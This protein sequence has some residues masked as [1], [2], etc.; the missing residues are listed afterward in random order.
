MEKTSDEKMMDARKSQQ[1]KL[2]VA[3]LTEIA[4]VSDQLG[5]Q[6]EG[7]E[8]QPTDL[9]KLA[10]RLRATDLKKSQIRN[11][12]NVAYTTDKISDITDLL[13]KLIGRDT[14][15]KRW[16]KDDLGSQLI[17]A[18]G[19]LRKEANQIVKDLKEKRS[20]LSE[21]IDDDLARRVHLELCR[22][23]VKHLAAQFLYLRRDQED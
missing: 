21:V 4:R 14:K 18:L 2:R 7:G 8:Q 20:D 11:L 9:E 13:K 15:S 3:L 22:E 6:W 12:E 17:K 16:A 19:E 23:Y 1:A 10:K 5:G